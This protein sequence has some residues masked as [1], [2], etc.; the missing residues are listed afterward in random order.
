MS[1]NIYGDGPQAGAPQQPPAAAL[2]ANMGPGAPPPEARPHV[3]LHNHFFHFDG[4]AGPLKA[5]Q[6]RWI[7]MNPATPHLNKLLHT[8]CHQYHQKNAQIFS[9]PA[10]EQPHYTFS[11]STVVCF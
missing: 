10:L 8:Q 11:F 3:N 2:G 6:L 7:E 9:T 5:K 1:L 4:E